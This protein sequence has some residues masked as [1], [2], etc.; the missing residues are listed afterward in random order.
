MLVAG[1]AVGGCPAPLSLFVI[2]SPGISIFCTLRYLPYVYKCLFVIPLLTHVAMS[3]E[4]LF[5]VLLFILIDSRHMLHMGNGVNMERHC[6]SDK[7]M[8]KL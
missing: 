7:D 6:E 2:V 4:F 5:F 8:M 1:R 3:L